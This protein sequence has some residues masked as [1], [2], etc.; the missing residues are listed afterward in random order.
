MGKQR[1]RNGQADELRVLDNLSADTAVS[2]AELDAVE[3]FLMAYVNQIM[4][5]SQTVAETKR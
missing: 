3:A 5:E 4:S 1:S 2:A